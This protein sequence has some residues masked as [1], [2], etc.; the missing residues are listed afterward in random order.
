M[1]NG[2]GYIEIIYNAVPADLTAFTADILVRDT[3]SNSIFSYM[4][5]R[6][7]AKEDEQT[8]DYSRS[9][10]YYAEFLNSLGLNADADIKTAPTTNKPPKR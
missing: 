7:Y 2:V 1:N 5:F 6:S 8:Y 10:N 4:L 3:Y 9:Q